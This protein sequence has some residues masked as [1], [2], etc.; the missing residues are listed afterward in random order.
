MVRQAVT[1][2]TVESVTLESNLTL[3]NKIKEHYTFAHHS[4]FSLLGF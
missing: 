2:V 4:S 3:S 1:N